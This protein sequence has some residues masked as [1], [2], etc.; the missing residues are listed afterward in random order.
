MNDDGKRDDHLFR[1]EHLI[2]RGETIL[3]SIRLSMKFATIGADGANA[4]ATLSAELA[5]YLA[6]HD[7]LAPPP[8]KEDV[9]EPARLPKVFMV[10]RRDHD[11]GREHLVAT[12][13]TQQS[14]EEF[15]RIHMGD[16]F[17]CEWRD[18]SDIDGGRAWK[19]TDGHWYVFIRE[20]AV[21]P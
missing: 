1:I 15:A 14:A 16:G 17:P 13:S 11:D 19:S 3:R 20:T 4:L 2:Q 7:A 8:G 12:R 10:I 5:Y 9:V 21:D 6:R 18:H